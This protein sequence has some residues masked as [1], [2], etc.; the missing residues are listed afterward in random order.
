MPRRAKPLRDLRVLD[1]GCGGGLLAE[2]LARL[3]ARSPAIDPVELATSRR[4]ERTPRQPASRSTTGPSRS[5]PW[6]RGAFDL[7]V[8][9]E[10]DRA[11]AGARRVHRCS[12]G[13]L[14]LRRGGG[15]HD[16]QPDAHELREGRRGRRVS[17]ALAT[18][19]H[20]RLA[21]L[22]YPGGAGPIASGE[23]TSSV[24]HSRCVLRRRSG[25]VPTGDATRAS[26][27]CWPPSAADQP[28]N[29]GRSGRARTEMPSSTRSFA[30]PGVAR[31]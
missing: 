24:R 28:S 12:G 19:R 2:P 1:V 8:A 13:G 4:R 21:P 30:S 16:A 23:R 22:P 7:V 25:R 14:P 3:G 29:S 27:T 26:T 17:A 31:P 11:C 15:G 6:R 9:S 20:A 18:S 5:R 10:V